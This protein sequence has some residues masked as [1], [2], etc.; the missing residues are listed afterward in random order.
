MKYT[1]GVLFFIVRFW[2]SGVFGQ[3][4][5]PTIV[6]Q[7][8]D[9]SIVQGG[10][11][12]L[13]VTATASSAIS[14]QWR[15]GGTPILGATSATYTINNAHP[16]DGG[17][18]S[19]VVAAGGILVTS[20]AA[21]VVVWAPPVIT[22]A[23][24][25][26]FLMV[27]GQTYPSSGGGGSPTLSL[28]STGSVPLTVQWYKG[29]SPLGTATT[30]YNPGFI[31]YNFLPAKASDAGDYSVALTNQ[32]GSVTS[33]V[34]HVSVVDPLVIVT[35]PVS[36]TV[37]PGATATLSVVATGPGPISYQWYGYYGA[38]AGA[39][40][41]VLSFPNLQPGI[42]QNYYVKVTNPYQQISSN[43][44]SLAAQAAPVITQQPPSTLT[45]VNNSNYA[46]N[47]LKVLYT[48]SPMFNIQWYKNGL[49]ISSPG[50]TGTTNGLETDYY[51]FSLTYADAGDYSVTI[52]N[53]SGSVT[54]NVSHVSVIAPLAIT[55]QPATQTAPVGST[56]FLSVVTNA[57]VSPLTYQW[58]RWPDIIAGETS[59]TLTL[60]KL[61]PSQ[62]GS[63]Y[64]TVR[65][66]V[67]SVTSD[68]ADIK[69]GAGAT[70][71]AFTLQPSGVTVNPGVSV[72]LSS[73]ASGNP[74]PTFQWYKNGKLISG[75][76][77]RLLDFA[78]I[79]FTDTGDYTVVATNSAGSVTSQIAHIAVVEAPSSRVIA[80]STRAYAGAGDDTLITGFAIAGAQPKKV[81]IRAVGP[82]LATF[83]ISNTMNDPQV[84]VLNSTNQVVAANDNWGASSN[85]AELTAAMQSTGVF[86]LQANSKDAALV[87]TLSP[88]NYTAML[89]SSD[90]GNGNAIAE[91]YEADGKGST[92]LVAISSRAKITST[93]NSATA[94]LVVS[95]SA[96]KKL[97][98]RAVGPAL[99]KY[100]V[101]N[102]LANPK[103]TLKDSEQ[104][105]VAT[106]IGWQTNSN[107]SNLANAAASSGAAPLQDGSKD[108]ALLVTLQPG[109]YTA[110]AESTDGGTGVVLIEVYE[111]P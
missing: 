62:N 73:V 99:S 96:A 97:L 8:M 65:D 46:R 6:T 21:L 72:E 85:L 5:G 100:G 63:Y 40:S 79:Q 98:I 66:E 12:S 86:A 78:S 15:I 108:S 94:G 74:N 35:Q 109:L 84:Q 41:S 91:I 44:V 22:S 103:L 90:G 4:S 59:A 28:S 10:T 18:Y 20:S 68:W 93:G 13:S 95:G 1:R 43:T 3:T 110:I 56:I 101:V 34:C 47:T 50:G 104:Q 105:I 106:N 80:L 14:Y 19:V 76:T 26:N 33:S 25:S 16:L 75:A 60:S 61:Q 55:Q 54:S 71:P 48:G 64:V 87:T 57:G 53:E 88:G 2:V 39:T 24:P 32:V 82:T 83:G 49:P 31:A 37:L 23:F 27:A 81:L 17:Y 69:V 30:S 70:A 111:V 38:I 7:P 58:Y 51:W 102:A 42:P 9:V 67:Q 107:G 89:T 45:V 77:S 36:T 11:I 52:S 29:G 92:K